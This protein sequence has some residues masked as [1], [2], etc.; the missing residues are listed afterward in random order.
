MPTRIIRDAKH[1]PALGNILARLKLPITVSWVQGAP[2]TDAQNRLAFR[3]YMDAAT[4]LGDR[5]ASR[6][7]AE[8]KVVF[9]APILCAGNEP[10][11]MS[12]ETLRARF[13]HEEVVAFVEATELPMT[14]IMLLPEMRQYM[15]AIECHWRGLGVRLT[16]PEALKYETEFE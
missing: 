14:S 5:T 4:Q 8:S 13:G 3:W 11:R 6:A 10:F 15:D 9:A 12:W 7:R 2:R 16:D 1:I